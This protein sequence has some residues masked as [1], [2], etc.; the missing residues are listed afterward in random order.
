MSSPTTAQN[1]V[2]GIAEDLVVGRATDTGDGAHVSLPS[3]P[4]S[5]SDPAP[6]LRK[7]CPAPPSSV[8]SPMLPADI[9]TGTADQ[10]IIASCAIQMIVASTTIHDAGITLDLNKVIAATKIDRLNIRHRQRIPGIP[11]VRVSTP[12]PRSTLRP[13]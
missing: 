1:I 2:F 3:P 5:I 7:S 4:S 9:V 13:S 12:A 6:P 8:T 11:K 10:L